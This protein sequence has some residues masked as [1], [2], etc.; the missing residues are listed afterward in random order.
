MITVTVARDLFVAKI[1][2]HS[3]L[4]L[5]DRVGSAN[6]VNECN[7]SDKHLDILERI[8]END[9]TI[10]IIKAFEKNVPSLVSGIPYWYDIEKV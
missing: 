5:I 9:K 1:N 3:I 2:K 7:Y 8:M 10:T 6:G 4:L